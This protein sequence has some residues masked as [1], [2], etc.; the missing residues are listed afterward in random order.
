MTRS[1][2]VSVPLGDLQKH[3]SASYRE[4]IGTI[5][6]TLHPNVM[7]MAEAL[8]HDFGH[9]RVNLGH[10]N[11]GCRLNR[12]DVFGQRIATAADDDIRPAAREFV[13]RKD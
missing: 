8:V 1:I 10:L 7:T 2:T 5:Y 11:G 12:L 3:L 6:V 4:A 13:Q 9:A